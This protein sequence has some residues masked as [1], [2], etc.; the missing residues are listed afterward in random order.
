MMIADILAVDFLGLSK[1][2]K[3]EQRQGSYSSQVSC[4]RGNQCHN[5]KAECSEDI[6]IVRLCESS[7]VTSPC[8]R[9]TTQGSNELLLVT[10]TWSVM[11]VQ[12]P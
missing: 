3:I 4:C 12:L 8:S 7:H 2:L 11:Q 5:I 6:H 10:V 9:L 1:L